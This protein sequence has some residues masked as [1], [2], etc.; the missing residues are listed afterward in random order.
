MRLLN[1]HT[2]E[3]EYLKNLSPQASDYI[4]GKVFQNWDIQQL[5]DILKELCGQTVIATHE[6]NVS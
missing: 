4:L 1:F 3:T 6:A 5:G 2:P